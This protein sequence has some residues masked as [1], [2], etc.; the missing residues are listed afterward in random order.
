MTINL[1]DAV[2]QCVR[3]QL[4][5]QTAQHALSDPA[6][7]DNHRDQLKRGCLQ[8]AMYMSLG[9]LARLDVINDPLNDEAQASARE[10]LGV[11]SRRLDIDAE[12]KFGV[13]L[14]PKPNI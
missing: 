4:N 11:I 14:K 6:N 7:V 1:Y 9:V 10:L 3:S 12:D 8:E 5:L 2:R 13:P